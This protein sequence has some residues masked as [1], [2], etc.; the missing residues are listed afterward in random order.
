MENSDVSCECFN[1]RLAMDKLP[2]KSIY[3]LRIPKLCTY[4]GVLAKEVENFL[5]D[6]EQY[7][8]VVT[9]KGEAR[10]VT[11]AIIYLRRDVKL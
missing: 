9:I 10:K 1:E 8:L 11:K 3:R 6:M 7:F 5:L 4:G 2:Y